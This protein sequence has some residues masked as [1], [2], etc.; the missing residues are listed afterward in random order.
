MAKKKEALSPAEYGGFVLAFEPT[1]TEKISE[2]LNRF[3]EVSES[4]STD[5]WTFEHCELVLLVRRN[6]SLQIF[7]AAL[8]RTMGGGGGTRRTKMRMGDPVL[9]NPPILS[10]LPLQSLQLHELVST[11]E[12]LKRVDAATWANILSLMK[13]SRPA[14]ATEIDLLVKR[15][16]EDRRLI[17]DGER[18]N[19]LAEE[20]D[21]IGLC[22]DIAGGD[23]MGVLRSAKTGNMDRAKSILDLLDAQ[24]IAERSIIEHDA[25][26]FESLCSG[27]FGSGRFPTSHG[28]EVRTYVTDG[29]PIETATGVD[30]LIYQEAYDSFLMLQYKGMHHNTVVPGWSYR[31]DGSNLDQQL[32]VMNSIRLAMPAVPATLSAPIRDQRL[33]DEPFYFKFCERTRPNARDDSLVRG[34]TISAPHLEHFLNQPEA[35]SQGHGRRV[36]Y[37]NCPRY[38]N[39]SEFVALTRAGWIGCRTPTSTMIAAI[40]NA[41]SEGRAAI[42]AVIEGQKE[43]KSQDKGRS[44]R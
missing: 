40:L 20:R 43:L 5:D 2:Y 4:F 29:T 42:F 10:P 1:R 6:P 9:F 14:L 41:R 22:L 13:S 31:V 26:I 18:I 21:A 11:A 36:G 15:R 38:L 27:K 7:A 33:N 16:T 44:Y 25:K 39:N 34:I 35:T 17:G 3:A 28:R 24:P 23:R 30:L 8:M 37:E 32:G 12:N 19:R